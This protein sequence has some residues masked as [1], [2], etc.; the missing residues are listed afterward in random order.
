M[1]RRLPCPNLL[2]K[3]MPIRPR[4]ALAPVFANG[5]AQ[6][7]HFFQALYEDCD[8]HPELTLTFDTDALQWNL[9]VVAGEEFLAP[10][11]R[12]PADGAWS[13]VTVLSIML[14]SAGCP[15]VGRCQRHEREAIQH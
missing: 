10:V 6:G 3:L 9:N 15:K 11:G 2:Q 4:V 8:A 1:L 5:L 13:S 7:V 14:R 12:A